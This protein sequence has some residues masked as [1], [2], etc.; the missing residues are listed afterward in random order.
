MHGLLDRSYAVYLGLD[1]SKGE[2]H[3]CALAQD[4]KRLHDKPLSQDETR[5]KDAVQQAHGPRGRTLCR[6]RNGAG[7]GQSWSRRLRRGTHAPHRRPVV[8]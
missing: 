4:G 5:I 7:P 2:H 6:G 3:A 8:V 1:V